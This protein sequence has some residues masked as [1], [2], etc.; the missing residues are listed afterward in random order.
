M[1]DFI[2]PAVKY[3]FSC[4]ISPWETFRMWRSEKQSFSLQKRCF[5]RFWNAI[6]G[7]W[8]ISSPRRLIKLECRFYFT[9][10]EIFCF[11]CGPVVFPPRKTLSM[12]VH[13]TKSSP[14]EFVSHASECNLRG[15]RKYTPPL[16][17][18][19]V[20]GRL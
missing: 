17:P 4:G 1:G 5:T 9:N 19:S 6:S 15:G 12:K 13:E 2:S 14:K 20:W 7:G 10:C 3:C 11:S 8:N 16:P 18:N